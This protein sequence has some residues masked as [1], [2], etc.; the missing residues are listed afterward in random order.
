[1]NLRVIGTLL[2]FAAVV[3]AIPHVVELPWLV[4]EHREQQH[5]E[6]REGQDRKRQL[7]VQ[8]Q[9]ERMLTPVRHRYISEDELREF[10]NHAA[11]DED[12]HDSPPSYC[13]ELSVRR[14]CQ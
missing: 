11:H 12:Y 9:E 4:E 8:D 3:W 7:E 10:D 5:Q 13:H 1:M 6:I 14:S 2:L